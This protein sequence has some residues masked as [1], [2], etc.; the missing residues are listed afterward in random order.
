M[1]QILQEN[2]GNIYQV[3]TPFSNGHRSRTHK[4]GF[5][6]DRHLMIDIDEI[7]I[8]PQGNIW[9]VIEVKAQQ[10]HPGSKLKNI[11]TTATYQKRALLELSKKI[12]CNLFVHIENE[13]NYYYL[14]DLTNYKIFTSDKFDDTVIKRNYKRI[15]TDN[16]IFIEFRMDS[17]SIT[18]VAVV[19]RNSNSE[20]YNLSE[21]LS[22]KL[23]VVHVDV[24]DTGSDITFSVGMQTVGKV[25][26]VL[27]PESCTPSERIRLEKEWEDIYKTIGIF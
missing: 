21:L 3:G 9:S 11:L 25:K 7:I 17:N 12:N 19:S 13:M 4:N 16:Q 5:L 22:K 6:L 10:P 14:T 26:S 8:D 2:I 24:D 1:N 18:F 23:G 20:I 27:Y 15:K